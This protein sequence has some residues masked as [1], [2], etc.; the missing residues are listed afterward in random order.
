MYAET[1][2]NSRRAKIKDLKIKSKVIKTN[3]ILTSSMDYCRNETQ[4][5]L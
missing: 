4:G 1:I 2:A 5:N 3:N